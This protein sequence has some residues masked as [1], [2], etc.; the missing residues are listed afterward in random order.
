METK[1]T[2]FKRLFKEQDYRGALKIFKTFRSHLAVD[3]MRAVKIAWEC[4]TGNET[5]YKSLGIDTDK[6]KLKAYYAMLE[7]VY[8]YTK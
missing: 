2:K 1:T 7:Y 6:M 3:E 5:F 8:K 4:S